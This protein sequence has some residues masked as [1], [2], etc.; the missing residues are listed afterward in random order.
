MT[1]FSDSDAGTGADDADLSHSRATSDSGHGSDAAFIDTPGPSDA[2]VGSDSAFVTKFA[3]TAESVCGPYS[4]PVTIRY[5]GIDITSCVIL[6]GCRFTGQANGAVGVCVLKVKDAGHVFS[7]VTGRTIT[8]EVNGQ[9]EWG[10]FVSRVRYGFFF[11]GSL[12]APGDVVRYFEISGVDWNIFFQKRVIFD[13]AKPTNMQLTTFPADTDDDVVLKYYLANHADLSGDGISVAGIEHVG[14]P[15]QDDE[16]SGAA[17][18][19]LGDLARYLRFNTGAID[20]ID[21]DRDYIHTD[22]DTPD[23]PAALTDLVFDDDKIGHV[24]YRELEI[25][26]DG[27][28]LRNDALVWGMGQGNVEAVFN[29]TQDGDS[30]ST[31]GL[32][33][34]ARVLTSV[35][36]QE[37][38]DRVAD[39]LVYGSPQSRRGGKDD[40][41]AVQCIV[42]VQGFRVGQKVDFTSSIWGYNEVLPIRTMEIDF[43]TAK[44]PRYR[45]VLSHEIDDPWS[46]MDPFQ[47]DYDIPDVPLPDLS[48]PVFRLPPFPSLVDIDD[49][50][51]LTNPWYFGENWYLASS[52]FYWTSGIG[53]FVVEDGVGKVQAQGSDSWYA[54]DRMGYPLDTLSDTTWVWLAPSLLSDSGYSFAGGPTGGDPNPGGTAF[55]PALNHEFPFDPL[56]FPYNQLRVVFNGVAYAWDTLYRTR[57]QTEPGDFRIKTW[58]DS[59]PEPSGWDFDTTGGTFDPPI[60]ITS[61]EVGVYISGTDLGAE[62]WI[63]QISSGRPFAGPSGMDA[64]GQTC[65]VPFTRSAPPGYPGGDDYLG[66]R[67]AFVPGTTRLWAD[68]VLLR[69][70]TDYGEG[71]PYYG[72]FL[73]VVVSIAG[74]K[75]Y[76]CYT[77]LLGGT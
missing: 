57:V 30:I 48:V 8:L 26:A 62:L 68:G 35:W 51:R 67:S 72:P 29:R 63:A 53:Y 55:F 17:G 43:P 2:G 65:E 71:D 74:K 9:V 42:F 47:F 41:R 1:D 46:S 45:M 15:S 11:V 33:Q 44:D 54:W 49:F 38:V 21:P 59:D 69:R 73:H 66:I 50:E 24:R 61:V 6:E 77:A 25:D 19:T 27:G 14:T 34:V 5:D 40:A 10:G 28:G 20:Y 32:W 7:F 37:T 60:E 64:M 23:A 76:V 70:G 75:M 52:G 56:G 58:L 18:W 31:H 16:I 39:S 22:V 36:R 3:A 4:G 13:K 12:E